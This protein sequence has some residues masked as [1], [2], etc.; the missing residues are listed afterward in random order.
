MDF[1]GAFGV[2]PNFF[3]SDILDDVLYSKN[4]HHVMPTKRASKAKEM[5]LQRLQDLHKDLPQ[6]T[7]AKVDE[8]IEEI[9]K[10][11]WRFCNGVC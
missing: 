4:V 8:F 5:F 11:V 6:E 9:I 2:E 7:I 10:F 3:L 1:T